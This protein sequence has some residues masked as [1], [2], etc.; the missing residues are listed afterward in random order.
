MSRI[1][2]G[3]PT[4]RWWFFSMKDQLPLG[5]EGWT[6]VVHQPQCTGDGDAP[7]CIDAG[8]ACHAHVVRFVGIP[9]T[10][11]ALATGLADLSR[12]INMV[13]G[14][15]T[16]HEIAELPDGL[17]A[18]RWVTV[19]SVVE[20]DEGPLMFDDVFTLVVDAVT[21][22]RNATGVAVADAAVERLQ[23]MYMVALQRDGGEVTPWNVVIVEHVAPGP[24]R[25][26]TDEELL[27]AQA[28]LLGRMQRNPVEQFRTFATKARAAAWQEGNYE[29]AILNAA[30][31]CEVLIKSAA[32]MLS[33]EA[34]RMTADPKPTSPLAP[35]LRP[36]QLIG[37]VLQPRLGGSW[38]SKTAG[39]PVREWRVEVA[40]RRNSLLHLGERARGPDADAAVHAMNLLASHVMDRLAAKSATYPRTAYALVGPQGLDRRGR[41][42][43]TLEVL[44]GV[45]DTP[46]DW[47]H[48]FVEFTADLVGESE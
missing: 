25:P 34:M 11:E 26:A 24:P 9:T 15:E 16:S 42:A 17:P 18:F 37:Q 20:P 3:E 38:D 33:F 23:P 8:T 12:V 5:G 10:D 28:L 22:L 29:G 40:Q 13:N 7:A 31:A 27:E 36:S 19:V 21:A 30:I 39:R 2:T 14:R 4:R 41:L 44:E 47:V 35:E 45:T 48:A 1:P 32:W 6:V 46:D 43:P